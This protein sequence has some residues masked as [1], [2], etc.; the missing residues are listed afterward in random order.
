MLLCTICW[1]RNYCWV[2]IVDVGGGGGA[3]Q[4]TSGGTTTD[5]RGQSNRHWGRAT[6]IGGTATDIGAE[7]LTWGVQQLTWGYSN[8]HWG[9][10]TDMGG[11][12]TDIRDLG[13]SNSIRGG[14]KCDGKWTTGN[15]ASTVTVVH[16][17]GICNTT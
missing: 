6:D 12:A 8:R 5:I 15:E 7:Q 13:Q 14:I 1:G 2:T 10:A 9:R 16:W 11:T 4:L 3:Q 17:N